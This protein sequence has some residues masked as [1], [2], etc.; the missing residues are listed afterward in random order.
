[1]VPTALG[2]CSFR[3]TTFCNTDGSLS[4]FASPF[5]GIGGVS[6]IYLNNS[7]LPT[8][9]WSAR[10]WDNVLQYPSTLMTECRTIAL[11]LK[12]TPLVAMTNAPGMC[13]AG[14]VAGL[15]ST[16]LQA[17]SANTAFS[18]AS[19][20]SFI[21]NNATMKV[22][23]RPI[24]NACYEFLVNNGTG[25]LSNVYP[26]SSPFVTFTG[27]PS[28]TLFVIEAVYH[29]EYIPV[30]NS[31]AAREINAGSPLDEEKISDFFS[32]AQEAWDYTLGRLNPSASIELAS[33]G[34]NLYTSTRLLGG[35][36]PRGRRQRLLQ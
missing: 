25:N 1:M 17:Y 19:L 12:V 8:T 27:F 3:S 24:D 30:A 14:A 16:Q 26:T 5:I 35:L 33:A 6:P 18:I 36:N 31:A 10:N 9:T 2:S 13:F 22:C 15:S 34:L 11:S 29:F 7:G 21:T 4:V 28:A 23:G 32:S 20:S